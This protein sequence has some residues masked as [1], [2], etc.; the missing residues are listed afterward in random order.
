MKKWLVAVMAVFVLAA[1]GNEEKEA[2]P[3]ELQSTIDD[4][5][6]GFEILGDSIQEVANV[7]E[8][9]K[10]EILSA[11]NDYITAFNEEDLE[12]Y[13]QIISK[14]AKGFKYEEDVQAVAEV[15]EQYDVSRVAEDVTIV[16][17]EDNE[18]QV[19]SNLKT[20]TKEI[21]TGAEL[22]GAG[23]QVTVLVKEDTWKVSSIYYI[24]SE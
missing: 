10:N 5:T 24:G 12:R 15:F 3:K 14:N 13:K 23:R 8:N 9:E 20:E 11:F 16:K 1:C 2:S 4:G 17:Y 7:P 21:E 22:S 19:F 18:A 6:V